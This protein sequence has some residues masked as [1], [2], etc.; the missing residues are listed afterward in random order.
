MNEL[1]IQYHDFE[2]AKNEIKK[3]SE[4]TQTGLNLNK[5]DDSKGVGEFLGDLFLGRGIGLDHMVTGEELNELTSQIQK[6][7]HSINDTQI[8]LIKEFGQVYSA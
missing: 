6:H 7:L 5:V 2:N 3:F 8:N 4:Q 1:T